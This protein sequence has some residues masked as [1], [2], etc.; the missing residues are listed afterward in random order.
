MNTFWLHRDHIYEQGLSIGYRVFSLG[1]LLWLVGLALFCY[2]T[3]RYYRRLGPRGRDN[4]R[5]ACGLTIIVLEYFKIIVLG[6]F[7]VNMRE[8]V[9]LHLCSVAGLAIAVYA[10]WP[11]RDRLNQLFAYAFVPAA[12]LALVFPSTTMYPWFNFYC[13]HGFVFHGLILA[14]F[15]W[16]YMGGE[17]VPNY[18]GLWL[19][20]L[21]ML[22]FSVPVYILDGAFQ[23]NYM[24]IGMRSDV[25]ILAA[26]W[27]AIV[28]GYGRLCYAFVLELIILLVCHVFYA[29]YLL[30][31]RRR[32]R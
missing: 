18:R 6:L 5:K 26:M 22:L 2:L 12:L 28:P 11:H 23:V 31:N 9:P 25:G 17:A 32:S 14:F 8:F 13:L 10:M 7:Q 27:D 29:V 3:G 30:L 4:M 20:C 24:F 15:V 21:F 1:H 19:A 16:L